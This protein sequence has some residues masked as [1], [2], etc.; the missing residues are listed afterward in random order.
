MGIEEGYCGYRG[1]YS[2]KIRFIETPGVQDDGVAMWVIIILTHGVAYP[3][4][5][6]RYGT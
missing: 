1:Q 3:K 6:F 5:K 2:G 4:S